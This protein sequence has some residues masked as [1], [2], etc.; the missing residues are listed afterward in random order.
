MGKRYRSGV[1]Q[2]DVYEV[3]SEIDDEDLLEEVRDR[4]LLVGTSSEPI[5]EDEIKEA[6]HCLIINRPAEAKA[7]LERLIMPKWKTVKDCETE[8]KSFFSLQEKQ[9]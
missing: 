4:K 6:L 5:A 7:I 1:I 2:I 8:Y 3:I 9:P